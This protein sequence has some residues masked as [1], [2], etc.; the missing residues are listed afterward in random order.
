MKL[1]DIQV[2]VLPPDQEQ[3]VETQESLRAHYFAD[4]RPWVVAYSGGKDS[5]LVLQLVYE[6]LVE[7]GPTA[8]KPIFVVASDTRVEAPN[9]EEYLADRLSHVSQPMPV[10]TACLFMYIACSPRP[11]RVSGAT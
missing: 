6:L 11:N 7:L 8:R 10:P 4:Q 9:V 5:T 3:V 2:S 1:Q